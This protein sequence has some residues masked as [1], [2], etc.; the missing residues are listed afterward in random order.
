MHELTEKALLSQEASKSLAISDSQNRNV[1][2][3]ELANFLYDHRKQI[4]NE[5]NRDYLASKKKNDQDAATLERLI[6]SEKNI[7]DIISGVLNIS[8][9]PDPIGNIF[10]Q[11]ELENELKVY[12][13][14]VP[15]GV[16][17][18]IY[19]SRPN[20]TID[21][22]ALC[23]KSGNC[24]ILRGGKEAINTNIYLTELIQNCL[25]NN[26]LP[27]NAI[28]LIENTDRALVMEM[29]KLKQYID[30]IIPRGSANL[31]KLVAENAEMPAV[32]GGIGI[33]HIYIDSDADIDKAISITANAKL[34]NPYVCNAL[35]TIL[36]NT[37]IANEFLP[38]IV[39]ELAFHD[40]EMKCDE[41]ALNI[42]GNEKANVFPA[43]DDDWGKEFLSLTLSIKIIE[44]V[45]EAISHIQNFTF[46]AGHTDTIVTEN[47]KAAQV[48]LN[49][50]DSSVVMLNASTRFNDGG[51][52]GLGAEVA[53]STSKF[54]ARG[55]MGLESLT[56]YKWV[57]EGNGHIRT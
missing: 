48:F 31:V 32:T 11:N 42:L 39:T 38:R 3:E 50:V 54:H 5:N 35:D 33:S 55:P 43:T 15:L 23:I 45:E 36:I 18:I 56:S 26:N 46:R 52:L 28:T 19:E 8:K 34:S 24:A 37:T 9:L 2:L 30:L 27:A 17:G 49:Q 4:L 57:V 12:K 6:L 41:Q 14:R 21:I 25:R 13:K 40:V 1:M 10:D 29:L 7:D 44:T 53:I 22:S 51:Q 20:V 16:I 47:P